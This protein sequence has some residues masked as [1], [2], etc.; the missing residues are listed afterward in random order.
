[1]AMMLSLI[2]SIEAG[3]PAGVWLQ[4]NLNEPL[5]RR[6]CKQELDIDDWFKLK[7]AFISRF[8][9]V[10]PTVELIQALSGLRQGNRPIKAY[11]DEFDQLVV[12]VQSLQVG[13]ELLAFSYTAGLGVDVLSQ[14]KF[15][16]DE[17]TKEKGK[18][19]TLEWVRAKA[20]VAAAQVRPY[21]ATPKQP[22]GDGPF[23]PRR[24]TFRRNNGNA[25]G[26]VDRGLYKERTE[27]NL[28]F[29]CGEAGHYQRDCRAT[30]G[31]RGP[32]SGN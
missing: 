24:S 21:V 19:P 30:G 17:Y 11:N 6:M 31:N 29:R 7:E 25:G 32:S 20:K 10:D 23:E 2:Q 28:C 22:S 1:M 14:L 12:R 15:S 18:L 3:S 9:R 5:R 4:A 13:D 16:L 26:Y 8:G 27:G